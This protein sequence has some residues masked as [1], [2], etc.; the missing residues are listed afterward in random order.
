MTSTDVTRNASLEDLVAILK[1]QGARKLDIVTPAS[2]VR[3]REGNFVVK[4]V[5]P[6]ISADG[7]TDVN[8]AYRPTK[9]FDSQLATKLGIPPSFLAK[10]R[11]EAIDLYDNLVNGFL[12]GKQ[13]HR[14]GGVIEV[15]RPG[16]ERS[17]MGRFF[18]NGEGD[19][20]ARALLS[21]R[22][23]VIDNYDVLLSALSG[24]RE[25]GVKVEVRSAD[26]TETR[27]YVKLH[28]PDVAALAPTLLGDYRNPFADPAVEAQRHHGAELDRWRRIAAAEGQGY[29]RGQEPVI[30]AGFRLSNSEVGAGAYT[31]TP[32][33]LV[34]VCKNGLV[35]PA[36]SSRSVHLGTKM[37][38]G[39]VQ[40]SD[41]TQ[42][43]QLDLIKAKTSDAVKHFLSP[44]F[45]AQQVAEI[46]A[47][48][49]KPVE[50]PVEVIKNLGKVLSF[51][52]DEVDGILSHFIK[53]GQSTAGGI[54][55]SITSYS[56]TVADADRADALDSVAVR[57]MSL[58]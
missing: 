54:L 32:E 4:G 5:D 9:H 22:Y 56:Q 8:G 46:E 58:V 34:K 12:H 31:L 18:T 16:D 23:N 28:S 13:I 21:D 24:I 33:L 45:L 52:Q 17:F 10:L 41:D 30:H 1:D 25:A 27:M 44:Q 35:L 50:K 11:V 57:A 48:A 47:V 7:V 15:I 36:L 40:W 43:K 53:G 51:S 2:Q 55:Q 20:V 19:G 29:E 26:L 14:A 39:V 49:G 37:S 3:A 42:Q 38:E 6:Q